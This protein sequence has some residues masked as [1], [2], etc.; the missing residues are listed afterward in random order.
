MLGL[1]RFSNVYRISLKFQGL[2][3]ETKIWGTAALLTYSS[4][5]PLA[6]RVYVEYPMCNR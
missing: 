3:R 5:G 4:Y 6:V 2:L 1:N